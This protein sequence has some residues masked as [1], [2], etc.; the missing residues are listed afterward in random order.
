MAAPHP[1]P[2]RGAPPLAQIQPSLLAGFAVASIGGPLA[3]AYQ[4]LP[5]VIGSA[6]LPSIG[7]V[8]LVA[9]ALFAFPVAVWYRYSARIASAGGLY[10][11]V[12]AAA[13]RTA[14]RIHGAVWIVS[15][16]LYLPATVTFLVYELLP[17]LA[18]GIAPYRATL[19]LLVPLAVTA[20][21]LAPLRLSLAPVALFAAAQLGL[22]VVLGGAEIGR[23]GFPLSSLGTHGNLGAV[24]RGTGTG[25]LLFLCAS[26][27]LYLGAEVRRSKAVMGRTIAGASALVG[28]CVLFAVIPL[29]AVSQS[30]VG[31]ELPAYAIAGAY[32]GHGTALVAGYATLL[33]ILVLVFAEFVALGRLLTAMAPVGLRPAVLGIGAL[34]LASDAAALLGPNRTYE[35]MVRPSL[36]ALYLSLLIVFVVY[37]LFERSRRLVLAAPVALVASAPLAY[38]FYLVLENRLAS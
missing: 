4:L 32:L 8:T 7:L 26:L 22:L 16:F 5:D 2:R 34:F 19:E 1:L 29:A 37:P 38:G 21:V 20:A 30:L 28:L 6:G 25:S 23:V 10:A 24:A 14:A 27:P 31:A 33:S 13:G 18:P 9:L 36:G 15:Y 12:E 17:S 11:F 3:L 35:D